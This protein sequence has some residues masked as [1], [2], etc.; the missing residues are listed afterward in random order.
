M[1]TMNQ[2][3][4]LSSPLPLVL[5]CGEIRVRPMYVED[6][7]EGADDGT[8]EHYPKLAV[9]SVDDWLV[10][11]CE[12]EVAAA[13]VI[14]RKRLESAFLHLVKNPRAGLSS[15]NSAEKDAVETLSME[16]ES[17]HRSYGQLYSTK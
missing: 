4:H 1:F 9:L 8:A 2:T 7:L 16:L 10:F 12:K 5:L 6:A 3:S 15:L 11:Q 17:A 14:L 13:V